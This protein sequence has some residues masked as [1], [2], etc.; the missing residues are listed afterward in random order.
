MF[1]TGI[2]RIKQEYKDS[3]TQPIFETNENSIKV[4]LPV[5]SSNDKILSDTENL[6]L[7]HLNNVRRSTQELAKLTKLNKY[8]IIKALNSLIDKNIISRYGTGRNT[9]YG[10]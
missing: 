9:K 7:N 2:T 5:M 10:R 3:F 4:V 6:I 8:K 1:G